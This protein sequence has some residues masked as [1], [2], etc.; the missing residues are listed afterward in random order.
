MTDAQ[1]RRAAELL[2]DYG[3]SGACGPSRQKECDDLAEALRRTMGVRDHQEAMSPAV[4]QHRSSLHVAANNCNCG[5]FPGTCPICGA[6][7]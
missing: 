4:R 1:R 2:G 7:Y 3:H 5:P 6:T